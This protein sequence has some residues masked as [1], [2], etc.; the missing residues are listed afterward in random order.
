MTVNSGVSQRNMVANGMNSQRQ[1]MQPYPAT[2]LQWQTMN[3]AKKSKSSK[4]ANR[5]D[6]KKDEEKAQIYEEFQG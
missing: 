5:Q 4:G 1:T 6:K 2:I 3:F